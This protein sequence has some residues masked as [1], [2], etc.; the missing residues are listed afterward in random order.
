MSASPSLSLLERFIRF[1]GV[2]VIGTGVHYTVLITLVQLLGLDAVLASSAGAIAGAFTNYYLNYHFTFQSTKRHREAMT[3]F[4]L[5]A[6]IAFFANAGLMVYFT[7]SLG[8]H[9][10]LA[11]VLTT[12]V[13]LGITFL[14]N[15]FWSFNEQPRAK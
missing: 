10:L 8:F 11:Q 6:F 3:K 14:G 4:M 7:D 5:I 13:V 1:T 12:T 9:Y 2:G 15:H